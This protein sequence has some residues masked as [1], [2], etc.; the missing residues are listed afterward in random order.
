MEKAG[1]GEVGEGR[2]RGLILGVFVWRKVLFYCFL[3]FFLFL[4]LFSFSV[5]AFVSI[6]KY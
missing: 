3:S 5:L 6:C 4:F 1:V 2:G